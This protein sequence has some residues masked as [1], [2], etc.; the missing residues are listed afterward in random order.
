MQIH[1]TIPVHNEERVLSQ[2]VRRVVEFL[3]GKKESDGRAWKAAGLEPRTLRWE[4][5]IA[6]NGSTDRTLEIAEATAQALNGTVPNLV[7][8]VLH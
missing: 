4:V 2:N 3:S 8:K 6:E 1:L 5:V 7:V